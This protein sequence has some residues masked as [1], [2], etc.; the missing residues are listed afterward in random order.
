LAKL[1]TASMLQ[2]KTTIQGLTRNRRRPQTSAE[3]TGHATLWL[4]IKQTPGKL[5]LLHLS[6]CIQR[7]KCF[8]RIK[9]F[10]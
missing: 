6:H 3:P 8:K 10:C 5:Y 9:N 7:E 2:R 4:C 1:I